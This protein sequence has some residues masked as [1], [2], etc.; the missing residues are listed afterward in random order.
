VRG[1]QPL[2]DQGLLRLPRIATPCTGNF[3]FFYVLLPNL[4]TRQALAEHLRRRGI[5]ALFHY[6]PLHTSPMGQKLGYR[7]GLLPVTEDLSER[8]LRLPMSYVIT[9][10]E[11]ARVVTEMTNFLS[12]CGKPSRREA[13]TAS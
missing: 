1:L 3:H 2:E 9:E 7:Q 4:D 12:A 11:Q 5:Q 10:T 6:V 8:L 13:L